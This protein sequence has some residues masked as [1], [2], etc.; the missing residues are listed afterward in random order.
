MFWLTYVF[1][2]ELLLWII[3]SYCVCFMIRKPEIKTTISQSQA[4][5]G[6]MNDER[7][8]QVEGEVVGSTGRIGSFVMQSN[9]RLVAS[10]PKEGDVAIGSVSKKVH[11]FMLVYQQQRSK[12]F[13]NTLYHIESMI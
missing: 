4:L 6:M 7:K 12:R 3:P 10:P 1:V 11:Q 8:L 13:Y 2:I 5:A 9:P